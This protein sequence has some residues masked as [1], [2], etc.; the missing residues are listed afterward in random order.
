MA[1]MNDREGGEARDR[2]QCLA[3][4]PPHA[5]LVQPRSPPPVTAPGLAP[6]PHLP[7]AALGPALL[8]AA[9]CMRRCGTR[10][11]GGGVA[12]SCGVWHREQSWRRECSVIKWHG[13]WPWGVMQ[14]VQ[15][16]C[17]TQLGG[18]V[19]CSCSAGCGMGS[20]PRV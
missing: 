6:L 12:C 13:E 16:G 7:A 14:G 2:Y 18:G 4:C 3:L 15:V 1:V 9:P 20:G 19:V 10:V 11:H 5:A 8:P 17:G